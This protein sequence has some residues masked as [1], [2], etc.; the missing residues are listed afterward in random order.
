MQTAQLSSDFLQ[1]ACST[2]R[3]K[4]QPLRCSMR[5]ATWRSRPTCPARSKDGSGAGDATS[6]PRPPLPAPA[7]GSP[8]LQR[9]RVHRRCKCR[10][11]TRTGGGAWRG[12]RRRTRRT[13]W[14]S[15]ARCSTL[16]VRVWKRRTPRTSWALSRRTTD[17]SR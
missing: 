16:Q 15:L 3:R 17:H 9:R 8:A 13:D 11:T 4:Q 10:M 2:S 7:Q 14:D 12:G 6:L 5:P 1:A